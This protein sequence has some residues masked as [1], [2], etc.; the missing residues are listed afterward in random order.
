MSVKSTKLK[1]E[2]VTFIDPHPALNHVINVYGVFKK[3]DRLAIHFSD[4][5]CLSA[6]KF[7]VAFIHQEIADIVRA[8]FPI[9]YSAPEN[10]DN[11][12]PL[13]PLNRLRDVEY[14]DGR[15]CVDF[16]LADRNSQFGPLFHCL[17]ADSARLSFH[18][19][20]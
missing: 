20:S 9:L 1:T 2:N 12:D 11:F 19:H 10:R 4:T 13:N 5:L 6:C 3:H 15:V 7:L 18:V 8:D 16:A 14:K 17:R